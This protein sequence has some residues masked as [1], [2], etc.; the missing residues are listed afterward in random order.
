[1]PHFK[2][3]DG[4]E[5]YYETHGSGPPL[6]LVPGLGGDSR[7]W[8]PNVPELAEHFTVVLHDHR[9]TA[10]STLSRIA[11]SVA[12]MADDA[13]QLIEGLGF[14]KVHWCGHS[15]GGAMGQVLAIEHGERIDRL[16]LSATWAK[17]D[18]FFRRLFEV[19]AEI[20]RELGPTAYVKA[21][22]L[23][24]NMPP[25]IRDHAADLDA[26]AAKANEAI[27]VPEIVLSR[28]AAIVAHDRRADLQRV[29]APTL[30]IVARDDMVT[31]LYFTEEL[32]RL[33]PQARAY[34]L[35]D[36]GHFFPNIHAEEFRRVLTAFL[37]G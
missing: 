30:A 11:Y 31:P 32:V 6:F 8:M 1:M 20:L 4:A 9:G 29:R 15:T 13:L 21:S 18:A 19:R 28:I 2:L 23:S 24:L 3:K 27:P 17:T 36:G 22:A 10:R 25:W 16:V 12:Q 37:L 35:P 33:I 26:A 7:F 14:D 34:V 5:L